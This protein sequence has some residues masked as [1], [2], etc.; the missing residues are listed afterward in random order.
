MLV[1]SSAEIAAEAVSFVIGKLLNCPVCESYLVVIKNEHLLDS[2][3]WEPNQKERVGFSYT[4]NHTVSQGLTEHFDRRLL[5]E[6]EYL[7]LVCVHDLLMGF[8]GRTPSDIIFDGHFLKIRN[9]WNGDCI[10][11]GRLWSEGLESHMTKIELPLLDDF[12]SSCTPA[13]RRI[14]A[15]AARNA[16]KILKGTNFKDVI[17]AAR[18]EKMLSPEECNSVAAYLSDQANR[19]HSNICARLKV[20]ALHVVGEL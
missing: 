5:R 14:F 12:A 18:L 3:L 19:I 8:S 13:Q 1:A 11:Y 7:P 9:N 20:G 2:G 4:S 10:R 6:W 16:C 15:N 17:S